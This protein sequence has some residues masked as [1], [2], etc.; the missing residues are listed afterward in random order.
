MAGKLWV[1]LIKKTRIV[2]S[3]TEDCGFDGWQ[4]AL[5]EICHQM[6]VSRPVVLPRHERDWETFGMTQFL[7]EHFLESVTFDRMELQYIDPDAKKGNRDLYSD[8]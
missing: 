1:R 5:N 4:E 8:L 2:D 3:R 6:D 7:P